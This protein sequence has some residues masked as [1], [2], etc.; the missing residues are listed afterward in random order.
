MTELTAQQR[1]EQK[2]SAKRL[3]TPS[4][5][6]VRFSDSAEMTAAEKKAHIDS[7]LSQCGKTREAALIK[8]FELLGESL[9]K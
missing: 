6:A 3:G 8:A 2:R 5:S 4:F 7:I 9:K 1:A